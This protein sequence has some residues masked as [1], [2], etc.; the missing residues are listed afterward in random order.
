MQCLIPVSLPARKLLN[1]DLCNEVSHLVLFFPYVV[2][3]K[4]SAL[5]I[6][7]SGRYTFFLCNAEQG[8]VQLQLHD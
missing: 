4:A 2:I 6:L 3:K 5:F 1:A 8:S 7:W